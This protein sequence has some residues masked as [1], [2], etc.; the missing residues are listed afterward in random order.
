MYVI[1]GQNK[2]KPTKSKEHIQQ[3]KNK[4]ITVTKVA[5]AQK[6]QKKR[7]KVIILKRTSYIMSSC[8]T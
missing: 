3:K 2:F 5:Y 1:R 7:K 6:S 4:K 8:I